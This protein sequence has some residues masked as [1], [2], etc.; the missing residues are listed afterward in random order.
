[1]LKVI[2]LSCNNPIFIK[3]QYDLLKKFLKNDFEFIIFNDGKDW[4]DITNFGDVTMRKQIVEMCNKLGIKCINLENKHHRNISAPSVR[5]SG[6]LKVIL[7]YMIKNKDE[8]FLLD[9]DMFLVDDLNIDRY[10]GKWF[11]FSIQDRKMRKADSNLTYFWA[12]SF[13]IDTNSAKYLEKLHFEPGFYEGVNTDSGGASYSWLRLFEKSFP[14]MHDV[15]ISDKQLCTKNFYFIK[16]LNSGSWNETQ[17]PKKIDKCVLKFIQ[18][19][20]RPKCSSKFIFGSAGGRM[21]PNSGTN[22]LGF[23]CEIFDKKFLHIGGMTHWENQGGRNYKK[24]YY[25]ILKQNL[26]KCINVIKKK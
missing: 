17:F 20:P 1:M 4:P 13:Y 25:S 22:K 19:D 9:S 6:N 23:R 5:H 26:I 2:V 24:E 16:Y 21:L 14:S 3:L 12:N 15:R 7:N 8:Y 18:D 11:A 10:R